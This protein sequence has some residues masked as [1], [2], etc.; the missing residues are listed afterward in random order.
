ME[1]VFSAGGGWCSFSGRRL[2]GQ[3]DLPNF[4]PSSGCSQGPL[5]GSGEGLLAHT[6]LPSQVT[7]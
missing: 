1:K 7:R 3:V 2:Y 4:L 5:G 6:Y